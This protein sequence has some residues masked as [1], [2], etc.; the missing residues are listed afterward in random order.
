MNK[1]EKLV[2]ID[3]SLLLAYKSLEVMAWRKVEK[4]SSWMLGDS[5]HEV[6]LSNYHTLN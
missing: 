5:R 2:W 4:L 1:L 6:A 3:A